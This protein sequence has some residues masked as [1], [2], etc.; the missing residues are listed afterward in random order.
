MVCGGVWWCVVVWCGVKK[1]FNFYTHGVPFLETRYDLCMHT[2]RKREETTE[3]GFC[4]IPYAVEPIA[5]SAKIAA[6]I[7]EDI[8]V[9]VD[10]LVVE[11]PS[12]EVVDVDL[13]L[14]K[15]PFNECANG[16]K[17]EKGLVQHFRIIHHNE[18][19]LPIDE[20]PYKCP[21]T[22][23]PN[24]YTCKKLLDLHF[25]LTNHVGNV[26]QEKNF[27]CTEVGCARAF[28]I[29]YNLK[30]HMSTHKRER[31]FSCTLC[32]A[33][34]MHSGT[35][36]DHMIVHTT[37]KPYPCST[38]GESFR[39]KWGL[40]KHK[41]IHDGIKPYGCEFCNDR[42]RSSSSLHAHWICQHAAKDHPTRVEWYRKRNKAAKW[43]YDNDEAYRI[44]GNHRSRQKMFLITNKIKKVNSTHQ[45]MG[46]EPEEM[47]DNLHDNNRSYVCGDP[48]LSID[49]IRPLA[50]FG[51]SIKCAIVQFEAFS[52]LNQQLL[53]K[54]ENETKSDRYTAQDAAIFEASE[55][56]MAIAE[57]KIFWKSE[58]VCSCCEW[59]S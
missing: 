34:F 46:C 8:L 59:C 42:F 38:C 41:W 36:N 12:D 1:R 26:K 50:N 2:K 51:A 43:K 9:A 14:W 16:Y 3:P 20:R 21:L 45:S 25:R 28:H 24:A 22:G 6:E 48:N 10:G 5:T 35:R 27:I 56:G 23:C 17:N 53:T 57:L 29:S 11:A 32:T 47:I 37:D 49:H 18:K 19:L 55:A 4:F 15:C 13:K 52:Y 58:G 30:R 33:T 7:L 40:K 54:R 31:N 39:S 44:L